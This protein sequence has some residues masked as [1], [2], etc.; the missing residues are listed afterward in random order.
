ME[1]DILTRLRIEVVQGT[2]KSE[3]E[4]TKADNS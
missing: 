3:A 1:T 2:R 4:L